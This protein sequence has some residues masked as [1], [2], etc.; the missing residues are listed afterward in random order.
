M[1]LSEI[2]SKVREERLSRADLEM[3][4]QKLSALKS[5]YELRKAELE[6]MEF[7]FKGAE[8]RKEQSGVKI[9]IEWKNTPEG[10]EL[11][12]IK[13]NI[14]AVSPMLSSIKSRIYQSY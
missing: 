8:H 11:I 4:E 7:R 1:N 10:Q 6:K 2:L 14:R 12:D 3:Y 5:Q 9:E 13:G